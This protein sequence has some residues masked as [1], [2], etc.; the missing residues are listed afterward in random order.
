MVYL[1][2]SSS[3]GH[4]NLV[5]HRG[6]N[7]CNA[8]RS[9]SFELQLA[10]PGGHKY[11]HFVSSLEVFLAYFLIIPGF[12]FVGLSSYLTARAQSFVQ[13]VF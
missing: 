2:F 10:L 4:F 12:L 9:C 6:Y 11:K 3:T 7:S 1:S 8:V 13:G 5:V